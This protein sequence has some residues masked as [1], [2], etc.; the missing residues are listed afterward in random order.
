MNV[1]FDRFNREIGHRLQHIAD[2][3]AH[4]QNALDDLFQRLVACVEGA[5]DEISDRLAR[6]QHRVHEVLHLRRGPVNHCAD[7]V[8]DALDE[9]A[10]RAADGIDDGRHCVH[11]RAAYTLDVVPQA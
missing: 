6:R 7:R 11:D 9:V 3:A 4:R 2:C 1:E 10:D 8:T 5:A